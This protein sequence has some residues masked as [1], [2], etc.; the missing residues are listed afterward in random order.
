[1]LQPNKDR[2]DYGQL[3]LPPEGYQLDNAIATTYSLDLDTLISIPV[4]LYFVHSLD[5][6]LKTDI[7]QILDSVR[8]ASS[9]IKVFCQKGQIKVP[10]NQHRL[11]SFIE[12]CVVQIPPSK[13]SSF[14]PKVWVI[15]Y[16]NTSNAIKFRVIILSRNLTF[17]RSWDVAFQIEGDCYL[18]RANNFKKTKPLV[19]FI[20]YLSVFDDI[21]WMNSFINDLGKTDFQL[22]SN[23]FDDFIFMPA[24]IKGHEKNIIFDNNVYDNLLIISPFITV[25]GLELA[26]RH[27]KNI[28]TLLSRESELRKIKQDLLD[29]FEVFHLVSD[30]VEGEEKLDSDTIENTEIQLQDLHAKVYSFKEGWN[31]K[32]LIGSSNCS[33]RAM[34]N[35]IE[36]MIQLQ[37]KNSKIGPDAI[38]KELINNDL[39]I[40][41]KFER[42]EDVS[43]TDI[44]L[45]KQEEELQRIKLELV[46]SIL[47]AQAEKQEDNN[48][49]IAF[50]YELSE[51]LHTKT[52]TA[53]AYLL[54]SIDQK[55][56]LE[57]GVQNTWSVHNI[58]EL[59]ISCFLI[60]DL[61]YASPGPQLQFAMKIYIDNLPETRNSKIF[62]DIISNTNNFFRYIRFLLADNYWEDQLS[63]DEENDSN[64]Q[65]K[66]QNG[67]F[68]QEEPIYENMLKA[69]SR[70]PQK[71]LEIKKVMDKINEEEINGESIIPV[72]FKNLWN[73]FEETNRKNDDV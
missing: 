49:A 44:L 73:V 7:V 24:G 18:N 68:H 3:L 19:D 57:F 56:T 55:Q 33:M 12:S 31:S 64:H 43:D 9:S 11:Y 32:L 30:F 39:N 40:F 34:Q 13:D 4:A 21:E 10:G 71:L 27:S 41:Q 36:F 45:S 16:K 48:F 20:T 42:S 8:R 54:S 63:F 17:D 23:D 28:I 14:H 47:K 51:I 25:G 53:H 29:R 50:K 61:R 2:L 67:Y 62:T 58:S 5:V 38:F 15:R 65:S 26:R 6:N 1:M 69:I 60:I 72:D 59:D 46:N 52:I 35:N 37:G 70:D 66:A 22:N